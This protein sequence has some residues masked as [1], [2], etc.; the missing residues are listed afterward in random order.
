MMS[1]KTILVGSSNISNEYRGK[2]LIDEY[3]WVK[4]NEEFFYDLNLKIENID[5][6]DLSEFFMYMYHKSPVKKNKKKLNYLNQI[7]PLNIENY[8]YEDYY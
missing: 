5:F 6:N 2:K 1:D 3:N 8:H 4:D 7:I